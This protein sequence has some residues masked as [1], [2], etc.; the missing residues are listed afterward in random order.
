MNYSHLWDLNQFLNRFLFI[1]FS[2]LT[3]TSCST[4]DES[5]KTDEDYLEGT[6]T[7]TLTIMVSQGRGS[8]PYSS[9]STASM[10]GSEIFFCQVFSK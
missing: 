9:G 3:F 4:D 6:W 10:K 1:F 7:I 2:V 5:K 8:G